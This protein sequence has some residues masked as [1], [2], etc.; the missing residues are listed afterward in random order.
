MLLHN[1]VDCIFHKHAGPVGKLQGIHEGVCDVFEVTG[2]KSF[3]DQ[4]QL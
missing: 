3:K 4:S 2:H 1:H